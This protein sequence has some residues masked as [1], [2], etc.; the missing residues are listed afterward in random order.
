MA[1]EYRGG[2]M[3]LKRLLTFSVKDWFKSRKKQQKPAAKPKTGK[4]RKAKTKPR[5][6]HRLLRAKDKRKKL[7]RRAQRG[8]R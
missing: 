8:K 6:W 5:N 1:S 2:T 7:A 4:H 3:N